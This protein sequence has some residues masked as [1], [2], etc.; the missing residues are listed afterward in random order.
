M[1]HHLIDH[2]KRRHSFW[3][4]WGV[5]PKITILKAYF[6]DQVGIAAY[7]YKLKYKFL[8]NESIY[9]A[10]EKLFGVLHSQN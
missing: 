3:S 8:H 9:F 6:Q 4:R 7:S 1:Q 10:N 2:H 5:L